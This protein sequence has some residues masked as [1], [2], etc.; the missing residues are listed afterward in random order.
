MRSIQAAWQAVLDRDMGDAP[1]PAEGGREEEEPTGLGASALTPTPTPA[2]GAPPNRERHRACGV[3]ECSI[4]DWARLV[5]FCGREWTRL[6][7]ER[8]TRLASIDLNRPN[9]EELRFASEDDDVAEEVAAD[10][11][12]ALYDDVLAAWWDF[13][14]NLCDAP[15]EDTSDEQLAGTIIGCLWKYVHDQIEDPDSPTGDPT[16]DDAPQGIW[17]VERK[18]AVFVVIMTLHAIADEACLGWGLHKATQV[19]DSRLGRFLRFI[20]ALL[21][22]QG[23]L[24]LTPPRQ[25]RVVPKRHTPAAGMTLPNLSLNLAF[26]RS[27]VTVRW[28]QAG[29]LGRMENGSLESL[30]ILLLP[31]PLQIHAN[32]F[33]P[34]EELMRANAGGG[35]SET[36]YFKYD[37]DRGRPERQT[38]KR[39]EHD[40][41]LIEYVRGAITSAM[42]ETDSID[43]VIFP[44]LALNQR[45]L[46]DTVEDILEEF[47]IRAYVAGVRGR[48]QDRRDSSRASGRAHDACDKFD[49]NAVYCRTWSWVNSDGECWP[50]YAQADEK[51]GKPIGP[52]DG[53]YWEAFGPRNGYAVQYKHHRWCL[54]RSQI[55]Q[56]QLG[57]V[58]APKHNWWEGI[59]LDKRT[60]RFINLGG[61]LTLC[62]LICEDLARFDPI[63]ALVRAVGPSLVVAVLLDGPQQPERWSARYASVLADDPGSAVITLSP[64]GMVSRFQPRRGTPS[65]AIALWSDVQGPP[66]KIELE[67]GAD[68][69][70]LSV[71]IEDRCEVAADGRRD[72]IATNTVILGGVHQ[73]FI[74]KKTT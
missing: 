71:A 11:L 31:W 20:E 40:Q 74:P 9:I 59:A 54:T 45:E 64:L 53:Q 24:A 46:E 58:L 7:S 51:K 70:L 27:P 61:E 25:C 13:T 37:P 16:K 55:T 34:H 30:S 18:W 47:D 4:S 65:R 1:R 49:G 6:L 10:R 63:G 12:Q 38:V 29:L 66:R 19:A 35:A 17:D 42:R 36:K 60:V 2:A 62:P 68:A 8:T 44:E 14:A 57:G 52:K 3:R 23:T 33:Q 56:Y 73:I 22:E 26:T 69:V 41:A 15:T 50:R 21:D 39:T 5:R 72:G 67:K 32:D 28:H 48:F 43:M